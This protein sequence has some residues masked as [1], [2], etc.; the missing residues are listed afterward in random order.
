MI[1][2]HQWPLTGWMLTFWLDEKLHSANT[3]L[4]SAAASLPQVLRQSISIFEVLCMFSSPCSSFCEACAVRSSLGTISA[5]MLPRACMSNTR[6]IHK[7]NLHLQWTHTLPFAICG[8]LMLWI[9]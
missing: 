3:L 4:C 6:R 9:E 2:Q 8:T 5:C 7:P 1:L